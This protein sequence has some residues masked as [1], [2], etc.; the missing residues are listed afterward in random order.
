[1]AK[2]ES[3]GAPD[4]HLAF[5]KTEA[6]AA[7]RSRESGPSAYARTETPESTAT[8]QPHRELTRTGAIVGTPLYGVIA[9]EILTVQ[10]PFERH[11][12]LARALH[13]EVRPPSLH[14]RRPD[15]D[16]P[17]AET[18]EH[19]LSADPERRPTAQQ[20]AKQLAIFDRG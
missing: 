18:I 8:T 10:L 12:I 17:L 6:P 2:T 16:L 13:E 7:V 19:S 3:G 14:N 15:L 20:L 1:M 9:F 5:A 11:A 4:P